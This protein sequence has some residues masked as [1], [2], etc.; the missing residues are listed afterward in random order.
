MSAPARLSNVSRLSVGQQAAL[1][2]EA[3][4]CLREADTQALQA[5][6]S[7]LPPGVPAY[8]QERYFAVLCFVCLWKEESRFNPKPLAECL[9]ILKKDGSNSADGRFRA[10]LDTPWQND[11]GYL[12]AKL[13]RLVRQIRNANIPLYPDFEQLLDDLLHWNAESRYVQRRWMEQYVNQGSFDKKVELK[14]E[15]SQIDKKEN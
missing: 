3:G 4:H 12:L 5:F 14:M 11:E 15:E 9:R 13:S 10:L 7:A 1:K 6:F 8:D 2:R